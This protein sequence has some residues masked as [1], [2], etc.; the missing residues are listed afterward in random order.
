M[1]NKKKIVII[2]AS[3]YTG[4]ELLKIVLV[5][6]S[7]EASLLTSRTYAGRKVSEIF[8]SLSITAK[9]N[10]RFEEKPNGRKIDN[11]DAV[12]LCLPPGESMVFLKN[13]LMDYK[14]IIIDVGSDFR[15]EDPHDY[16]KWYNKEHQL[17]D[18]LKGFVYGLP[19]FNG[20]IISKT[21][22]IANP[23]C[24]PTSVLMGVLPILSA[25][26][27]IDKNIIV[28]SKS[29]VTGAGRKLSQDYLFGNLND[30][31]YAYKPLMHRHTGEME[32]QIKKIMKEDISISFTPHLLPVDR[33]I[34]SSIYIKAGDDLDQ[35]DIDNIFKSFAERNPFINYLYGKVPRIKDV[36]GNN[37]CNI[38][39]FLDSRTNII[40]VFTVID[41]LIKGAA[42]QAIQNLNIALGMKEDEGLNSPGIF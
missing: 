39:A 7:L 30:N 33:G 5:H 8:P 18:K 28:D 3:G 29:G 15:I 14:G 23:G 20:R 6:E 16:S 24:Y 36:V 17:K 21:R 10:I 37:D 40:K 31:F 38:G 34:F 4:L 27:E 13:N 12:F 22:L 25:G 42:G 9:N 2:G 35:N 32:T 11:S 1:I 41:N 26:L 19:E